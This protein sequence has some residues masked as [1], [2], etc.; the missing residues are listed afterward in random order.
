M[1]KLATKFAPEP[2]AFERAYQ[3]GFRYAEIWLGPAV[4]ADW[5]GVVQQ[6]RDYP[7]GYALHFP[8]RLDLSPEALEQ[9]VSLSRGL[10]SRCLVIHQP[11][12]DK[13]REVLL[14]LEPGLLLA[15][16]NHRLSPD[17][18]LDWAERNDGLALDVEH[19]WK[20]TLGDAPL[21]A[22]LTQVR[23]VRDRFG[24]KLRHG[25]LPGYWR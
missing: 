20:F 10:N 8:N 15:V 21:D 4:L 2:A 9:T 13:Y 7:L 24:D 12:A 14:R 5:Q 16:E 17:G 18:L 3:A 23:T 25:H 19:V 6:A 22:L 11:M 1:L